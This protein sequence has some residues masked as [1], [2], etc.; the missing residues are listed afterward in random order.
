M[1][2]NKQIIIDVCPYQGECSVSGCKKNDDGCFV[3]QLFEERYRAENQIVDLNKMVKAKEQECEKLKDIANRALD[4]L[5][6]YLDKQV[7]LDQLKAENILFRESNIN[8]AKENEDLRKAEEYDS[9]YN[10]LQAEIDCG[11]KIIEKYEKCLAEIRKLLLK[12]PT[13]SQKHCVN[14]KSVI[15]QKIS[16]CEVMNE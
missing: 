4:K 12:T 8:L 15:L 9:R 1:L 3:R 2:E 13:D 11:N 16:E 10:D 6:K 7:Q 14:A 5:N